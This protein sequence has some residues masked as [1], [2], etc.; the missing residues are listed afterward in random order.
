LSTP[1]AG[2]SVYPY[3]LRG[4]AIERPNQVW[5]IDSTYIRLRNVR[6]QITYVLR[7]IILFA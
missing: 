7:Y 1:A 5:G 4:L 6:K 3:L 2:H